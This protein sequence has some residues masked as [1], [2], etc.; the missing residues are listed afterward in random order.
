VTKFQLL[1]SE[2]RDDVLVLG[3]SGE[4]DLGTVGPLREAARTAT[5]NSYRAV[6]FDLTRLAFIDSSGLHV[7]AETHRAMAETGRQTRVVCSSRMICHIFNL[8]GLDSILTIVPTREEAL[9]GCAL[10][11]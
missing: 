9:A 4:L 2:P 3:M 7:I 5:T 1:L 11:A 6:V 8:T 10:A